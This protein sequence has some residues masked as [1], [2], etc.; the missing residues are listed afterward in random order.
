M[1]KINLKNFFQSLIYTTIK[2]YTIKILAVGIGGKFWR[3]LQH[4]TT[5]RN[6]GISF[7]SREVF[8]IQVVTLLG[9]E[10]SPCLGHIF[11]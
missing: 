11:D 5:Q 9:V 4:I 2:C 6:H 3:T 10:P 8:A 1:I 7:F